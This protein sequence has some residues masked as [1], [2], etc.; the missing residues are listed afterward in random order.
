MHLEIL[1]EEASAEAAL[2]KLLPKILRGAATFNLV[3]HEGKP[4]LLKRLPDRLR[5]YRAWIP[6]DY[7]IIVLVDE[8]RE[9]CERLKQT[10]GEEARRAGFSTP[11][12]PGR[13]GGFELLN[14][15]AVEELEAWFFGDVEALREVYPR[16]PATLEQKARFRD[17]DA[18]K[19]GTWEVLERVLNRAGYFSAGMPKIEVARRVAQHME[20][21]R[22]RSHS[23][24]VFRS[25]LTSLLGG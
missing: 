19:G 9:D 13:R 10:L 11:S 23:F 8:D 7:R 12:K 21:E 1:V 16:V 14:P 22:N 20:P 2:R 4:D 25:G 15:I 3:V 24:Q 17:P 5:G 18:I 6:E